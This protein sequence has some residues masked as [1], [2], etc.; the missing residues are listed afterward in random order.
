MEAYADMIDTREKAYAERV[1]RTDALLAAGGA[2]KLQHQ[3][4]DLELRLNA[5]EAG[6]DVAAL[7]S[8]EERAQWARIT[9]VEEALAAQGSA[10][11]PEL[12]DKARLIKGVL[13]WRLNEAWKARLWQERRTFKDLDAALRETQNR[14]VRVEK[15]RREAPTNTGD[16]AARLA[17]LK[18]RL[19]A[20]QARLSD[21]R[22]QQ[23]HLLAELAARELEAQKDRLA[24]YQIQARFSLAS[25][26]DRAANPDAKRPAASPDETGPAPAVVEPA[27]PPGPPAG[28]PAA[29]APVPPADSSTA[30]GAPVPAPAAPGEPERR[31]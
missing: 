26:Y 29:P 30:P 13:Y 15:A 14:W 8:T 1:P 20:L 21:A 7:G 23:N 5:I 17:A 6:G 11:D 19:D 25:I 24:T 2:E 12:R 3:R 4:E 31:P 27:N 9:R 10:A 16:F 22:G 28:A 18:A